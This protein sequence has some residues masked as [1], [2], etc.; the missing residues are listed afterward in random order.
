MTRRV[1]GDLEHRFSGDPSVVFA[2]PAVEL[3][4]PQRLWWAVLCLA[5]QDATVQAQSPDAEIIAEQADEW[6]FDD[7]NHHVG[8]FLWICEQLRLQPCRIR[9]FI[10]TITGPWKAYRPR[11]A[12]L[13]GS[14][15]IVGRY[16]KPG[17]Q[18][19]TRQ[20]AAKGLR[21]RRS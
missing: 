19:A 14:R 18:Y 7:L 10:D 8:S 12:T 6:I 11:Y 17:S 9:T 3:S 16:K 2:M 5:L 21:R 13:S 1:R 15:V 4:P 20:R